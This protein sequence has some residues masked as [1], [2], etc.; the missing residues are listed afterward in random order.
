MIQDGITG[1]LVPPSDSQSMAT[2][3]MD[4][5]RNPEKAVAMGKRGKKEVQ[6]KF[7]VEAMVKKYE[8]LY[9]SLLKDRG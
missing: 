2:A 5:L 3:I 7:T 8:E 9:F 6:E 1:Y 4:L